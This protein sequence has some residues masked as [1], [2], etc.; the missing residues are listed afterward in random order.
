MT[1]PLRRREAPALE[2]GG[3]SAHEPAHLGAFEMSGEA[4]LVRRIVVAMDGSPGALA[5][6]A[7]TARLARGWD[8]PVVAAR[9]RVPAFVPPT[10]GGLPWWGLMRD[11]GRAVQDAMADLARAGVR[12]TDHEAT[13]RI[14]TEMIRA[15]LLHEADLLAL[16]AA[17]H[18][19]APNARLGHVA[20]QLVAEAPCSVLLARRGPGL[21]PVVASGSRAEPYAKRLARRES[22]RYL[23]TREPLAAAAREAGASLLVVEADAPGLRAALDA[24]C[25]VLVV[26]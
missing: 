16:G 1:L 9:V 3:V 14:V 12:A 25:S 19:G 4:P 5:A 7:W 10:E 15:V 26:R 21:G 11:A 22:L 23:P 18:P 17:R 13:G 20:A 6:L 24:S 8:A 2:R